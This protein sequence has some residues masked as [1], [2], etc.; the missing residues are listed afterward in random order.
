MKNFVLLSLLT[1]AVSYLDI[2]QRAEEGD[3]VCVALPLPQRLTV[4]VNQPIINRV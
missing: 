3:G 4:K 1:I 2:C